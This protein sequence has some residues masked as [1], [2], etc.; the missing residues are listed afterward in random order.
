MPHFI[1]DAVAGPIMPVEPSEPFGAYLQE[2]RDLGDEFH[3]ALSF[4]NFYNMKSKNWP[5]NYNKG[6][7]H[8]YEL[9]K[10]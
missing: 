6:F 3:S 9:Q 10:T 2:Y 5:R 1:V 8:N 4:S 7:T